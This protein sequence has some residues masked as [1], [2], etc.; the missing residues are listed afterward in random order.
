MF[1]IPRFITE[2]F[3][4][5]DDQDRVIETVEAKGVTWLNYYYFYSV[6]AVE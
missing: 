1:L 5:V 2:Y 3:E 4:L 6:E